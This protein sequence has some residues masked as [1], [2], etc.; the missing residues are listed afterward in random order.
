MKKLINISVGKFEAY[1]SKSC[2][3][4]QADYSIG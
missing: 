4:K 2:K 1:S 3:I